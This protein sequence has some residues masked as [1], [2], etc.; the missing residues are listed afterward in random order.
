VKFN[1][2]VLST[3]LVNFLEIFVVSSSTSIPV[4]SEKW[5]K[6]VSSGGG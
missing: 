6:V 4:G 3:S 2:G 5:M 1:K